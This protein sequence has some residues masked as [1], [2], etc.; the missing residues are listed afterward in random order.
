[1]IQSYEILE[2]GKAIKCY[3]CGMV[4]HNINDVEQLY[5]GHCHQFHAV[6]RQIAPAP[7]SWC[8]VNIETAIGVG[9]NRMM[10]PGNIVM[11]AACGDLNTVAPELTFRRITD[12][13]LQ[14]IREQAPAHYMK[15]A[16]MKALI[17]LRNKQKASQN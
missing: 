6:E 14:E 4:S 1:M 17:T 10:S 7:C 11:C 12:V 2:D 13:E 5:C 16:S 15:I 8:G 9:H 3:R